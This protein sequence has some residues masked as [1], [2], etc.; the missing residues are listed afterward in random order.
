MEILVINGPNL[1]ML[2]ARE[3]SVYGTQTLKDIEKMI[4]DYEKNANFTFFQSNHEGAI[5]DELQRFTGEAVIINAGA[6]THYSYAIYD[7]LKMLKIKKAE[8][9]MSDIKNREPFRANSVL[10]AACDAVF[11]GYGA[12]SYLYAVDF[13]CGRDVSAFLKKD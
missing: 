10:T 8:V 3:P 12:K 9:H 11:Y 5:I 1:N 7:A 6:F 4:A 13:I 2:G